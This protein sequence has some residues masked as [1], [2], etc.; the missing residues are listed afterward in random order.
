MP[1]QK[2]R[3]SPQVAAVQHIVEYN[4]NADRGG[5]VPGEGPQGGIRP[6]DRFRQILA[7][8]G[9]LGQAVRFRQVHGRSQQSRQRAVGRLQALP[10]GLLPVGGG[11]TIQD[12]LDPDG[13]PG[14]RKAVRGQDQAGVLIVRPSASVCI[15]IGVFNRDH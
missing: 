15:L 13:G 11:D 1:D 2:D 5:A 4:S 3:G 8:V 7:D 14:P 10:G 9:F 12:S 6:P